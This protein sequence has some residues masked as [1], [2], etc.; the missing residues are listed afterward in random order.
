LCI[1]A[2]LDPICPSP[3]VR[4]LG[5]LQYSE[6]ID[7]YTSAFEKL[8]TNG[9]VMAVGRVFR[10]ATLAA[11]SPSKFFGYSVIREWMSNS[12]HIVHG[13]IDSQGTSIV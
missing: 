11:E 6:R 12:R 2:L 4:F 1:L 3:L 5:I 8:A 9:K 10:P 7:D 13:K